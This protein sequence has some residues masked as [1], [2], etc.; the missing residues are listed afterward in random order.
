M[1]KEDQLK[2]HL[3]PDQTT[4]FSYVKSESSQATYRI[5]H[6]EDE[7][8]EIIT[9]RSFKTKS[10]WDWNQKEKQLK[11]HLQLSVTLNQIPDRFDLE[12]TK[13][14]SEMEK[15]VEKDLEKGLADLFAI[16]QE[17]E[18]DPVGIGNIVRS[19]DRSW[20]EETFYKDYASLPISVDV[21]LKIIHSGLEG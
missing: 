12:K 11:L 2:L 8:K 10:N 14:T 17:N 5:Q 7:Q 1:F 19:Q 9:F 21:N 18:V 20:E 6:R 13:D 15:I 4:L 3:N 16:L